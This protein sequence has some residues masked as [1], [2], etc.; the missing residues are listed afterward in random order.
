MLLVITIAIIL[1]SP[2]IDA[3]ISVIL[4]KWLYYELLYCPIGDITFNTINDNAMTLYTPAYSLNR[5]LVVSHCQLV[6]G[7]TIIAMLSCC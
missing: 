7:N 5:L 2:W 1:I 4:I 3:L 6:S